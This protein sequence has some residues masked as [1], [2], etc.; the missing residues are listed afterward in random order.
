MT[1]TVIPR[2]RIVKKSKQ[3]K[4]IE[5]KSPIK[6]N[7][8]NIT[9]RK[10][11]TERI[12]IKTSKPLRQLFK[13]S[14]NLYNRANKL[15]YQGFHMFVLT[16]GKNTQKAGKRIGYYSL[17]WE[18]RDD[19]TYRALP[20]Q[21]AQQ[22][23]RA[24]E[25]NWSAFFESL[26]DWKANPE[27]YKRKPNPP[28][29]KPP[30]AEWFLIFTN[31]QMRIKNNF[32][33]FPDISKIPPVKFY[34]A[35]IGKLKI[36]RV[37]PRGLYS[38]IEIVY[39]RE[40]TFPKEALL[41]KNRIIGIDLG[42]RNVACIVGNCGL[43][44]III[45]GGA[46]KWVNQYYNKQRAKFQKIYA[47]YNIKRQTK[48]LERLNQKR[49]NKIEDLFHK[50]S[51]AIISYCLGNDIKII[52]IGYNPQWKQKVN[53]GRRINQ[54]FVNIPLYRLIQQIKYKAELE[55][56]KVV[57]I[58]ESHTSKC[59]FLD[60]ETIGHH[61]IYRGK[62]GVYVSKKNGGKGGIHHGLFQ[63]ATG[64]IINS[65]LNG[66]Y[67]ILRKAFPNAFNADGIEGLGLVPY[68]LTFG[69]LKRLAKCSL[70]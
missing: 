6:K 36:V 70:T 17:E 38:I 18:L 10:K 53:L 63:T 62:R 48:R 4:L 12:Q 68:S 23:L 61:E 22:L 33:N 60:N 37:L 52:V 49:N 41:K 1:S 50:L 34:Q 3:T 65:D 9:E 8:E 43:R 2:K 5:E 56:I 20:A 32:L 31:Q 13:L 46:I 57:L 54:T 66:A 35:R 42:V 69:E 26:E 44:P 64:Q 59:S 30:E 14:K 51:R 16:K 15:V 40:L 67:N 39:E 29:Q 45:K 24:V 55:G 47:N 28:G 7:I 19:P 21:T 25:W 58:D 11:L 27:K